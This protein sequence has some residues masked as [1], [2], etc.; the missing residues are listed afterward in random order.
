MFS[1]WGAC[2]QRALGCL[3]HYHNKVSTQTTLGGLIKWF[4]LSGYLMWRLLLVCVQE[5][6]FYYASSIVQRLSNFNMHFSIKVLDFAHQ[7]HTSWTKFSEVEPL[8]ILDLEI[9]GTSS[10][11]AHFH[12]GAIGFSVHTQLFSFPFGLG[13]GIQHVHLKYKCMSCKFVLVGC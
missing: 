8:Y 12:L 4:V 9:K 11:H 13:N 7:F 3:I 10:Y 2:S 6:E 1:W 5:L